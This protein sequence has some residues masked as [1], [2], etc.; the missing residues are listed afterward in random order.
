LRRVDLET[1]PPLTAAMSGLGMLFAEGLSCGFG[2]WALLSRSV[3]LA[4]VAA[5]DIDPLRRAALMKD[6]FGAALGPC[7][8]ALIYLLVRWKS[9]A[10][11]A[12]RV[13]AIGWRLA[14]LA[15][16][17]LV[18]LLFQWQLWPGRELVF[19]VM[20]SLFC[21]GLQGL[22]RAALLAPPLEVPPAWGRAGTAVR[23]GA[24]RLA[25]TA[26]RL[27]HHLPL[28]LVLLGASLY[29]AFFGW[30][31]VTSHWNLRTA[32]LDLGLE[33]NLIWNA[34]HLSRP[35]FKSSPLGG[36][37]AVH[38]GYHA[39][40]ISYPLAL[41]YAICPRA[42]TL[43]IFQAV[44][45]GA[46]AIPLFLHARRHLGA[47][48]ACLVAYVYLLYPPVHGANL[49]DFHYLPVGVFFLWLTLYAVDAGRPILGVVA[50]LLTLSVREDVSA[51]VALVGAYLLLSGRRPRAGLAMALLGVTYFTVMKLV[52]MPRF[53]GGEAF[54]DAYKDL[55]PRGEKGFAGV[56]KTAIGNP[57]FT[58]NTLLDRDKLAYVLQ[59]FVP[60]AFLPLRRSIGFLACVIGFFFT[61]L[62]TGYMPFIQTSFQYTADWTP[63]LFM[64]T[65]GNLA[66]LGRPAD[67]CSDAHACERSRSA[68]RTAWLVALGAGTLVCSYQFGAFFQRNTIRGGFGPYVFGTTDADRARR[69][70]VHELLALVPRYAKIVASETLVPQ[71]SNRPDAYTLRF[72][73]FDAEYMIFPLPMGGQEQHNVLAGLQNGS[74]GV[75]EIREPF[76]LAKRGAP[77]DKNAAVVGR[78]R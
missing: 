17:G 26:P 76:V 46:A 11:A 19:L 70:A 33:E 20:A 45:V 8:A 53:L 77:T 12:R 54:V 9:F 34:L 7:A 68:R 30:A 41:I 25:Q 39:T 51:G 73:L 16:A 14:P 75:L 29:A 6:M 65:I 66:W 69:T 40:F 55:L 4:Y 21:L 13:H 56:L 60:L 58:L 52:V 23:R 1:A 57:G 78:L 32:S 24:D 42:E 44:M 38:F 5:N 15:L 71:V 18:P 28:A 37:N 31:T 74:F 63:Y 3:L 35:F 10:S 64:A 43:L 48:T 59:L 36:P 49:Y 2:V 22:T 47:W 67:A 50:V 27:F 72:G 61:L 62:S